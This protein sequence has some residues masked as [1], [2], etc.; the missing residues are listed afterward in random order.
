MELRRFAA[1]VGIIAV[2][3]TACG[4]GGHKKAATTAQAGQTTTTSS[5][6][7]SAG[8]AS[9]AVTTTPTAAA[10]TKS[11]TSVG[12]NPSAGPTPAASPAPP[13]PSTS[14]STGPAPIAPGKYTYNQQGTFKVGVNSTSTPPQGTLTVDAPSADG[15]QVTH[16]V[17]D[18]KSTNPP[19]DTTFLFKADGMFLESTHQNAG[20]ASLSCTFNPP[21]PTPPWP[22]AVGKTLSGHAN[23][24]PGFTT[25][26]SGK[27]TDTKQVQLDGHTYTV[28]V[29][30]TTITTHGS[31]ES[32]TT[33]VNWFSPDLRMTTHDESHTTGSYQGFSFTSDQTDDLVSGKPA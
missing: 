12:P 23:C 25:D 17:S 2:T 24:D 8:A 21:I 19:S 26:V 20:G 31:L 13:A 22:P 16:R 29:V 15:H 6:G 14:T 32:Q 27:I 28:Y 4:G 3:L 33:Q 11:P 30:E 5:A 18:P 10:G 9:T 7:A 1:H